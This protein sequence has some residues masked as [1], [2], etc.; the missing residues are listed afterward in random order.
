ML[1]TNVVITDH[2]HNEVFSTCSNYKCQRTCEKPFRNI[3]C[4]EPC[5]PG[6]ICAPGFLRNSLRKCVF[7][8]F[9]GNILQ[10]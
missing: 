10:Y 6:C 7:P 3:N 9:C 4:N 8:E 1:I 2:P 5:I